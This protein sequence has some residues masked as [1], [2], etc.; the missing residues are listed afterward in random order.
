MEESAERSL[1][2]VP[3]PWVATVWFGGVLLV[4]TLLH[5][6]RITE[7]GPLRDVLSGLLASL[8]AP[9]CPA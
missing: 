4:P 9:R 3:R 6:T 5:L 1:L 8:A 2:A 7:N